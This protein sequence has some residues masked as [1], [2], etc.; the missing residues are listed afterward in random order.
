MNPFLDITRPNVCILS[1][2][3]IIVGSIVTGAIYHPFLVILAV[4]AATLITAAG[5]VIN[6]FFDHEAD[7]H[8]APGRP[9]PSGKLSRKS[10][11]YYAVILNIIGLVF[12]S[13][14]TLDF[15]ILALINTGVLFVYAWKLKKLP[16]VGNLSVSYL[17]A[18]TFLA[19]G[20]I[21]GTFSGLWG[22]A[23]LIL[24][25]ISLFGTLSRE[26]FKDIQDMEGDKRINA[27]T[28]P[29]LYGEKI[30]SGLA[31]IILYYTCIMLIV[32]LALLIVSPYYLIGAVPAI[33]ICIYAH[34]VGPEKSQKLIKIAMYFVFLGFIT[35]SLI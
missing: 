10:A 4:V 25:L 23:I 3:G 20:L 2:L 1:I 34:R 35:G 32:P 19:S 7:S 22:S 5:N 28:L 29:I 30:S 11:L 15:L 16:F 8:N 6:D 31:Y 17:S 21:I 27:R 13:L 9:I 18:S 12:S 33:L 14:I 26:I 24:A